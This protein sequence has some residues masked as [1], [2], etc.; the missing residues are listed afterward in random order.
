MNIAIIGYGK[1]G[2]EIEKLIEKSNHTLVSIIDSEEEWEEYE[3][4]LEKA[5]VAIE[6]STPSSVVSNIQKC[7]DRNL[8]VVVGTTGWNDARE[9]LKNLCL[10]KN[11]SLVWG[12]NFSVGVNMFFAVNKKLAEMMASYP[13]FEVDIEEVHHTAKLDSPSGTALFLAND[14]VKTVS[15][16][17]GETESP[18]MSTPV[19]SSKRISNTPGT[20]IVSYQSDNETIEIKHMALNRKNF[21]QGALLAAEWIVAKKGFYS[22][23]DVY[24]F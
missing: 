10:E 8:P 20:H 11:Q 5:D 14:I 4:E 7:F 17:L 1:M 2:K 18:S 19:I 9:E 13:E 24:D 12:A 6:F 16:K 3:D 15:S 23:K 21:A 22:V